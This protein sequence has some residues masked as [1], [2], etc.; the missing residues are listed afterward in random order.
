MK[1]WIDR[2]VQ[3]CP[4]SYTHQR[5]TFNMQR[6]RRQL[7]YSL[8]TVHVQYGGGGSGGTHRLTSLR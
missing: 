3:Q 2:R 8:G 1:Q 4:I 7:K 6:R 5:C